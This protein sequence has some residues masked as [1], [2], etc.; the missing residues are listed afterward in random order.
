VFFV[1]SGY[2]AKACGIRHKSAS[3]NV[4]GTTIAWGEKV[5]MINH[6]SP[7]PIS[8]TWMRIQVFWDVTQCF[9][10]S[11]VVFQRNITSVLGLLDT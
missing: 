9:R 6:V 10:L 3:I 8:R 11:G 2:N 7:H 1:T 5:R 4:P